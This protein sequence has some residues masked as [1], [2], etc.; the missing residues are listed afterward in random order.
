[1]SAV[2]EHALVWARSAVVFAPG[3]IS[4]A[5]LFMRRR[6]TLP[7]SNTDSDMTSV[8]E[9]CV[10]SLRIRDIAWRRARRRAPAQYLPRGLLLLNTIIA[11]GRTD[12]RT[13][14]S[15]HREASVSH[16]LRLRRIAG[17][18]A[19]IATALTFLTEP[20]RALSDTLSF[21][22]GYKPDYT[23]RTSSRKRQ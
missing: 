2:G 9:S 15:P 12:D 8:R 3:A 13:P 23:G 17:A 21:S 11:A 4:S 22:T 16:T 10:T 18:V 14:G 19:G 1:M 7:V 5:S 20:P 6:L